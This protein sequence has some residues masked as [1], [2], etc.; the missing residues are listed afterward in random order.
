[1]NSHNINQDD[2]YG[3]DVINIF[4]D[5]IIPTAGPFGPF[6]ELES[7]S[8]AKELKVGEALTHKSRIYHFEGNEK[9][10][11]EIAKDILGIDL[12]ERVIFWNA[13]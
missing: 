5:G 10:L 13:E 4:N 11:N 6:Y 3:G 7:S 9:H 12:S 1:M 8:S 2:P